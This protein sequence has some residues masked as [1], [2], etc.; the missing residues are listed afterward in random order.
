MKHW[1]VVAAALIVSGCAG[2]APTP[3][4]VVQPTDRYMDCAAIMIEVKSNNEKVQQLA[5][6]KGLKVAQN[7][8]AGIAGFVV[9]VL[10]FGMDWQGS[11]DT[12]IQSLQNRQQ[13][14]A[15]LAE[16]RHCAED[17]GEPQRVVTE[18]PKAPRSKP[19]PK[20]APAAQ[21]ANPAGVQSDKQ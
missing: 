14:L 2:K 21:P 7:V 5:S 11:A 20:P 3:V 13:Y 10:W 12:E 15:A 9:P 16:Q 4:A 18:A 8:A 19:K 6:D 1:A 17:T